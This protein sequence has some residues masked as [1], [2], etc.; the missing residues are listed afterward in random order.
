MKH[1]QATLRKARTRS[2]A[3]QREKSTTE[4]A[5]AAAKSRAKK[6][7]QALKAAKKESK[8]AST[9]ARKTRKAAAAARKAL[10]KVLARVT[11]AEAFIARHPEKAAEDRPSPK[12]VVSKPASRTR[13]AKKTKN[14]ATRAASEGETF[15]LGNADVSSA[16]H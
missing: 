10:K 7:K 3:L 5:A 9:E 4:R 1:A 12:R 11:R 16:A 15:V 13:R 14:V 6:A 2:E 8:R